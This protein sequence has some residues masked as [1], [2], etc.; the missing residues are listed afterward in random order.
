MDWLD[1]TPLLIHILA[2]G[3]GAKELYYVLSTMV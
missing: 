3:F 2:G 1:N